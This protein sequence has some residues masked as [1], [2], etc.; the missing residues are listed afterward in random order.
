MCFED[1]KLDLE[2]VHKE[3]VLELDNCVPPRTVGSLEKGY[4][5]D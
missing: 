4:S 2:F 1:Y 5:T 3:V